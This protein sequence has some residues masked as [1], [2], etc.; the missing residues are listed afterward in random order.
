LEKY[1][2]RFKIPD[3]LYE[4]PGRIDQSGLKPNRRDFVRL[5]EKNEPNRVGEGD[6]RHIKG[7]E[8]PY[9]FRDVETLV[10]DFLNEIQ[11][12]SALGY[13]GSAA[14]A[15][16]LAPVFHEK[17]FSKFILYYKTIKLRI[18]ASDK[19]NFMALSTS[20]ILSSFK[21]PSLFSSLSLEIV[22]IWLVLMLEARSRP[23]SGGL[24]STFIG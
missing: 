11:K 4:W 22:S 7:K 12:T 2:P 17:Y 18:H 21:R 16:G 3:R 6:H 15:G 9:Q 10:A 13:C 20:S 5:A 23:P 19:L 24:T 8:E 1:L 14:N